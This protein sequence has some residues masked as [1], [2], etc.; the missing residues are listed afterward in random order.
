[1]EKGES[2]EGEREGLSQLQ[3]SAMTNFE[4]THHGDLLNIGITITNGIQD[5]LVPSEQVISSDAKGF[6]YALGGSHLPHITEG[7]NQ[8]PS[9]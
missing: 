8:W 5:S 9:Y 4:H 6:K 2:G 3:M 1:M 7:S